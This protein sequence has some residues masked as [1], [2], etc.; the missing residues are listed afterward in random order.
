MPIVEEWKCR[1]WSEF[2]KRRAADDG[3]SMISEC[4]VRPLLSTCCQLEAAPM[5]VGILVPKHSSLIVHTS[6]KTLSLE[7][8]EKLIPTS[9]TDERV[10]LHGIAKTLFASTHG[11]SN[12][13]FDALW[14]WQRWGS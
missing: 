8:A 3:C 7:K 11:A 6:R 5:L 4:R 10:D 13:D 12:A 1:K 9:K 2:W 14:N